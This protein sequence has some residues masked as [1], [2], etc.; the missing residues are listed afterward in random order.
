ME[1]SSPGRL[2]R[3]RDMTAKTLSEAQ[4]EFYLG[5]LLLH[6][7]RL[8]EGEVHLRNAVRLDPMLA[9]AQSGMGRLLLRQNK[10]DEAMAYLRRATE[11]DPE[12]LPHALLLRLFDSK[13]ESHAD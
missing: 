11:L 5:D 9:D 6:S 12:E 8:P 7:S 3:K 1:I 13:S 10:E 4:A 2:D